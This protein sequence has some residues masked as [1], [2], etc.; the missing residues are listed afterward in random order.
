MV[1][2][3]RTRGSGMMVLPVTCA[4]AS[5]TWPIS[6][7]RKLGVMRWPLPWALT[8]LVAVTATTSTRKAIRKR[9]ADIR[10]NTVLL[11]ICCF[12]LFVPGPGFGRRLV[13]GDH[14]ITAVIELVGF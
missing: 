12:L 1:T 8:T 9:R 5:M 6:T 7:S 13:H 3:L 2:L 4:T 10:F 14:P 11:F